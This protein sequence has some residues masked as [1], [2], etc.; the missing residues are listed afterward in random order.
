M[1]QQAFLFFSSFLFLSYSNVVYMVCYHTLNHQS[2]FRRS[3]IYAGGQ[4][5]NLFLPGRRDP[6]VI[7]GIPY[8][9]MDPFP[10][11]FCSRLITNRI[12]RTVI[13]CPISG[14]HGT[15]V[16]VIWRVDI[17]I[18]LNHIRKTDCRSW[19]K[20]VSPPRVGKRY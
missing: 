7:S 9:I 6:A 16:R 17:D 3:G 19:G 13:S 4:R 5:K 11:N 8:R 10:E 14:I 1:R 12:Y 2:I 15:C 20:A 18:R